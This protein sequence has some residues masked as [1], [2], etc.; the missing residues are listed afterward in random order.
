MPVSIFPSVMKKGLR[1]SLQV[2]KYDLIIISNCSFSKSHNIELEIRR[3]I[4]KESILNIGYQFWLR[5][6]RRGEGTNHCTL[7]S[8]RQ[9]F[10]D[11][12]SIQ[13]KIISF[14]G[15]DLVMRAELWPAF[16]FRQNFI[17]NPNVMK[18]YS[19]KMKTS[20]LFLETF[21]YIYII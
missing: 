12:Y 19:P 1:Q 8:G 17:G 7:D 6:K 10:A 11:D 2:W 14:A 5:C 18:I 16:K 9:F 15:A 20:F 13:F 3:R 21:I 4:K